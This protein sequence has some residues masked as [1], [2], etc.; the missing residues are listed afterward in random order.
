MPKTIS[1]TLNITRVSFCTVKVE[2]GAP[3]FVPHP[4]AIFPGQETAAGPLR[5]GRHPGH[6]QHRCRPAPLFH[7]AGGFCAPRHHH[8]R[9]HRR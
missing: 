6:H 1:R 8:R 9:R 4:D 5:Q 2:D 3:Q 7:G